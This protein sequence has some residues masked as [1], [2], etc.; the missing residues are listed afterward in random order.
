MRVRSY[1][2]S[3]GE[4]C[5]KLFQDLVPNFFTKREQTDFAAWL[6]SNP[7]HYYV[8][9]DQE[10]VIGCGGIALKEDGKTAT[11]CWGLVG[12]K[13]HRRGIGSLLLRHR[14][15]EITACFPKAKRVCLVTTQKV[16]HFFQRHGFKILKVHKNRI[17]PG[18]DQVD[19]EKQL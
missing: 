15:A 19:M 5:L 7:P 4:A 13:H 2:P 18:L 9:V 11:L 6:Y 17:G 1:A 12:L 16:Q 14:L 10:K 3:N 8:V